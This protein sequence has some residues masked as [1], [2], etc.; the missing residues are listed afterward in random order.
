MFIVTALVEVCSPPL[1]SHVLRD[2][3]YKH[4]NPLGS[5]FEKLIL[6]ALK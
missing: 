5:V 2:L 1:G 6:V 4:M 3:F